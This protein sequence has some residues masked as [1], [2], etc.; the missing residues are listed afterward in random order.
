LVLT[1][2]FTFCSISGLQKLCPMATK[3]FIYKY[4]CALLVESGLVLGFGVT[5]LLLP[6]VSVAAK[7]ADE[8]AYQQIFV[9]PDGGGNDSATGSAS[10]PFKTLTKALEAAQPNT[11]I[12]LA[13]G[14]YSE[15]TG[16]VFPI[17][18]KSG[19]TIRG[20]VSDRGQ[21]ILIRGSGIF[22]SRTFAK[23]KVTI[24]GQ[25]RSGLQG[26]TVSNPEE[27]GYGVW[28]E[29]S[30]PVISDNT[31]VASGHDGVSV[32]GSSAPIIRNNHFY[33]NGA[34]GITIYGN[35]QPEITENIFERTGFGINI[36]QNATPKIIGNRITGNKDG[37]IIQGNAKPILRNNVIDN[38]ERDGLV[39]ISQSQPD[40]GS[41]SDPGGNAFSGNQQLDI[42]AKA[43]SNRLLSIGNQYKTTAG[44]VDNSERAI[45]SGA[46]APPAIAAVV[47][48]QTSVAAPVPATSGKSQE[49]IAPTLPP[50]T[51]FPS[52]PIKASKPL[53]QR[54]APPIVSVASGNALLPVAKLNRS[55][56]TT[57]V[58]LVAG[59]ESGAIAIAVPAPE[60]PIVVPT[61]MVPA[62]VAPTFLPLSPGAAQTLA[63]LPQSGPPVL[64]SATNFVP[65]SVGQTAQPDSPLANL[66]PVPKGSIPVGDTGGE[67]SAPWLGRGGLA[68][69]GPPPPL[70]MSFVTPKFRVVLTGVEFE[71]LSQVQM[72]VPGAF[73]TVVRGQAVVQAGAFSD[74][75]KAEALQ[76]LLASQGLPVSLQEY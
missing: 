5:G 3:S 47:P 13:P 24:V 63:R 58:G 53:P 45:E 74:R 25:A 17:V 61:F 1:A 38:N 18:M 32:V 39:A 16:E 73:S 41:N 31:F 64:D 56:T 9:Q 33:E 49:A 11:I 55:L 40:L 65:K 10:A 62:S 19:V 46:I 37:I 68:L 22:L 69:G 35:S 52:V 50:I 28:V 23:Q 70:A 8:H 76:Q 44:Q 20:N 26:V 66:L 36:A 57:P 7:S 54:E 2:L 29:S 27:Q 51:I 72:L 71:R 30:S 43:S 42:N 60:Q 15:L 34:N 59:G 14:L 4:V 67:P 21:E 75:A 48:I 6:M 12:Q